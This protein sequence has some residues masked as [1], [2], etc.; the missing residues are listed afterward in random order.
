MSFRAIKGRPQT[1][2]VVM[3][4][5]DKIIASVKG[6]RHSE[7]FS[8]S[9]LIECEALTGEAFLLTAHKVILGRIEEVPDWK[10]KV[11]YIHCLG[12]PGRYYEYDVSVWEGTDKM[13]AD[14]KGINELMESTQELIGGDSVAG[15]D[16][17][18]SAS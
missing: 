14:E 11:F 10:G 16:E 9:F 15:A 13:L 18:A 3:Q 12:R 6:I 2:G 1:E 4:E 17:K 8:E 5:G 7:K